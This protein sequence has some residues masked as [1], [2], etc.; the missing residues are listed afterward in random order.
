MG[1]HVPGVRSAAADL[2]GVNQLKVVLA[3]WLCLG[4][5]VVVLDDL[6]LGVDVGARPKFAASFGGSRPK[7]WRS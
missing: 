7:G 4:P 6:T 1:I 3:K 5:R 2:S